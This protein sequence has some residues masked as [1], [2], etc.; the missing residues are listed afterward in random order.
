MKREPQRSLGVSF[1]DQVNYQTMGQLINHLHGR[2]QFQTNS[3]PADP[4]ERS[5][6]HLDWWRQKK[7]GS[8]KTSNIFVKISTT[9]CSFA[10]FQCVTSNGRDGFLFGSPI[11]ASSI[12]PAISD[13]P[14]RL[15]HPGVVHRAGRLSLY[16]PSS[17]L[18]YNPIERI[19]VYSIIFN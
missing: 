10:Q 8:F 5:V 18:L 16:C 9:L 12:I 1:V 15:S 2:P 14:S 13:S 4:V 11:S 19:H 6:L 17:K 7:P 3:Y